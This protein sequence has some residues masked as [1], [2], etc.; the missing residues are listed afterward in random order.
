MAVAFPS[1]TDSSFGS[2]RAIKN[3]VEENTQKNDTISGNGKLHLP[4]TETRT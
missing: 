1:I 2:L 3:N 4:F